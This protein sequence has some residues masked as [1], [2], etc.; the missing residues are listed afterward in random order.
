MNDLALFSLKVRFTLVMLCA[1]KTLTLKNE[2][3]SLRSATEFLC[4]P[5]KVLSPL[6]VSDYPSINETI[7]VS[8]L[9]DF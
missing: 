5:G 8:S 9:S 7:E 3:S 6:W 2:N 4:N 1:R